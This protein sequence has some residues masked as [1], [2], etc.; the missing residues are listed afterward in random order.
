VFLSFLVWLLFC[1]VNVLV[2]GNGVGECVY[3]CWWELC[4]DIYVYL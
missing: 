2:R 1:V 4:L 3:V